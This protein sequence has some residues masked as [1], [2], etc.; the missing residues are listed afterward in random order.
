MKKAMISLVTMFA[1]VFGGGGATMVAFAPSAGA[2][3][4]AFTADCTVATLKVASYGKANVSVKANGTEI[5]KQTGV[6]NYT[7]TYNVPQNGATTRYQVVIDETRDGNQYDKTYDITVGPC[8]TKVN[9]PKQE[10]NCDEI[11]RDF[12]RALTN[13]DHINAEVTDSTGTYQINVYVDRNIAGGYDTLGFRYS[14]GSPNRPLTKAEVE[15]GRIWLSVKDRVKVKDY[16]TVNF[17]Q[18]NESENWPKLKCGT[19]PAQPP[20]TTRT[21][22]ENRKDCVNGVDTRTGTYTTTYTFVNGK[23]VPTETGPVYSAWKDVRDLTDAEKKA[24]GCVKAPPVCTDECNIPYVAT[25]APK[26]TK[27][28]GVLSGAVL[29]NVVVPRG[30]HCVLVDTWVNGSVK[31]N[32]GRSVILA[33]STIRRNVNLNHI[34]GDVVFGSKGQA[35]RFDPYVGGSIFVKNSHNVLVCQASVCKDIVLKNNDGRITVRKS[36]A[37]RVVITHNKRF[38]SDGDRAHRNESVIRLIRVG[39]D[40]FVIKNNA[41][42]RVTRR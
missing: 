3:T 22:N 14:D 19:P 8:G 16:Y 36:T 11:Y 38:E 25:T 42:R 33:D 2:H 18:I 37:R 26:V 4:P 39:A 23:W 28:E 13:G 9:P 31:S 5:D 35:C 17:V 41:P 24:L 15:A 40:K 32:G 10:I 30:A 34:T 12:G 20:T 29:N 27:C 21:V 6:S 1:L 7:K